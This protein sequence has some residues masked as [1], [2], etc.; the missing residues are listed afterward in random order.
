MQCQIIE[1]KNLLVPGAGIANLGNITKLGNKAKEVGE[2]MKPQCDVSLDD[3]ANFK[4]TGISDGRN[5]TW[6]E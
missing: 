2:G 6:G 5:P 3:F 1:A 4:S